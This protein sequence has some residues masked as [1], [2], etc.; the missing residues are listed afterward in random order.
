[1]RVLKHAILGLL[2][3]GEMSGYDIMTEFKDK[4]LR[5]FWSA[6]HSQIYPE[7]KKLTD[8]GLIEFKIEIQGEK[9]EKKVYSITQE[10]RKE[11]HKWL[12]KLEPELITLKD[13]FMLKAYFISSIPKEEARNQFSNEL[14]KHKIRLVFLE[15]EF[16]KLKKVIGD[17]ITYESKDFGNYLALTNALKRENRYCEWLENSLQFM[18]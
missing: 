16:A 8:E 6:K 9:L 3:R 18:K 7:L 13:E 12:S 15:N 1:M 10:G 2:D 17:E 11:V 14:E 4:E 5:H